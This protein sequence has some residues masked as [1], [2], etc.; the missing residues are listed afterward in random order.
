MEEQPALAAPPIPVLKQSPRLKGWHPSPDP[1]ESMS[2]GR[3]TS[4]VTLGGPPAPSSEKSHPGTEHSNRAMPRYLAKT[5]T[6]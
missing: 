4:K 5:L 3:T 2:L 1:M 6:W